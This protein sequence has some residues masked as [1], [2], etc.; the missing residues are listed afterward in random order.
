MDNNNLDEKNINQ[1]PPSP[2]ESVED[3]E[4]EQKEDQTLS[5]GASPSSSGGVSL[6]KKDKTFLLFSL[7]LIIALVA[8][9]LTPLFGDKKSDV[10]LNEDNARTFMQFPQI[11]EGEDNEVYSKSNLDNYNNRSGLSKVFDDG[12]IITMMVDTENEKKEPE[13]DESKPASNSRVSGINEALASLNEALSEFESGSSGSSSGKTGSSPSPQSSRKQ[14]DDD[15]RAII[16][17]AGFDWE[18]YQR[19]GEYV[20]KKD[21]KPA[22]SAP[23]TSSAPSSK[24]SS[25]VPASSSSSSSGKPAPKEE[26][27]SESQPTGEAEATAIKE[28]KMSVK[29]SDAISS[30]DGDWGEIQGISSLDNES[31][32]VDDSHPIR[33]MFVREEKITSGQR[34]SLRILDD[35]VVNG[36]LLPKNTHLTASCSISDRL[37]LK[38][39]NIEI[40][41]KI[42]TL[43]YSAYDIDGAEGIYCAQ[44]RAN[45]DAKDAGEDALSEGASY[46]GGLVGNITQKAVQTGAQ[47]IRSRSGETSVTISSG[48]VFF[49]VYSAN[50]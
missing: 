10:T 3:K 7:I 24:S 42:Y 33:V 21:N 2:Q 11:Q 27:K 17:S 48:Y 41:G 13:K 32:F 22:P 43:N 35:M 44:T 31:S 25:S 49:L 50:N 38:V 46:L 15:I 16:E 37:Y 39:S 29:K 45:K 28:V 8:L 9:M 4:Q 5:P 30:L 26:V 12:D 14:Q 19:T 23:S 34:V 6:K 47:I 20:K 40:S 1:T 18:I 36:V